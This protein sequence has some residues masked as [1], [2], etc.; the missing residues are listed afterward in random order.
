MEELHAAR[1]GARLRLFCFWPVVES[2]LGC[3]VL[4]VRAFAE[5]CSAEGASISIR[6]NAASSILSGDYTPNLV[7][8]SNR[9]S[10]C[11]GESGVWYSTTLSR[12]V[13]SALETCHRRYDH[14]IVSSVT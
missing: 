2:W 1:V 12:A 9:W 14:P 8:T 10:R 7:P 6:D 4:G 5:R 3:A 13:I 11:G